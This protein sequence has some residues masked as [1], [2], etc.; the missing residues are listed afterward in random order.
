VPGVRSALGTG[1]GDTSRGTPGARTV[2]GA[3]DRI[4]ELGLLQP[5]IAAHVE[6]R[7]NGLELGQ[8]LACE[9][10]WVHRFVLLIAKWR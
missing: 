9:D 10:T 1:D 7:G 6:M 5:L 2:G 8:L 3:D 4:D